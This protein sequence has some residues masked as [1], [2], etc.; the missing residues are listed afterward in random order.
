MPGNVTLNVVSVCTGCM[1][2]TSVRT[3]GSGVVFGLTKLYNYW[4]I[5]D[6]KFTCVYTVYAISCPHYCPD[7]G[8]RGEGGEV[9]VGA[10]V[11]GKGN[12]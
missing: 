11:R 4:I 10:R 1:D 12:R 6:Y 9:G 3:K 2:Q 8:G 5:L 7:R